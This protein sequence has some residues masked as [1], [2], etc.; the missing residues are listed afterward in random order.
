MKI[1]LDL[2]QEIVEDLRDRSSRRGV[3][4][5]EYAIEVLLRDAFTETESLGSRPD[6]QAAIERSR[7]D[8]AAGRAIPHEEVERWHKSQPESSGCEKH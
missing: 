5:N 8:L 7:A 2:P 3:S 4:I 6:W 1:E